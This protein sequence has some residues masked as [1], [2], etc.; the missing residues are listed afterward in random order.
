[1]GKVSAQWKALERTAAKRLGGTR[2]I[3]GNDFSQPLLDVEHPIYAID[4]KWRTSLTTVRW[5][6][7]LVLDNKK[8]YPKQGKI[9]LLVLKEK[10]MRGELVVLSMD[11][12]LKM[13]NDK[14]GN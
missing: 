8:I 11:D 9:P 3:R 13:I 10:N 14:G 4:C 1:M 5:Y 6:E 7:K 2:I 12:F